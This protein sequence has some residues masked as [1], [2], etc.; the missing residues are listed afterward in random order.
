MLSVKQFNTNILQ[1]L[2][3]SRNLSKKEER[4][5]CQNGEKEE[6]HREDSST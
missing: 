4:W 3:T 1:A 6:D 5:S 2:Q